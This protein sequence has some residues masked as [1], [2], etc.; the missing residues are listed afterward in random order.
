[1]KKPRTGLEKAGNVLEELGVHGKKNGSAKKPPPEN[2]LAKNLR[3]VTNRDYAEEVRQAQLNLFREI[4]PL[5]G[6]REAGDIAVWQVALCLILCGL[7]YDETSDR[8]VTRRARLADGSRLSVTFTA[9][10]YRD[11]RDANGELLI[12]PA[13][14]KV[15]TTPIPL[16]FGADRGPLHF[17]INK[18]VLQAKE[19]ERQGLETT[20]AR[21]VHWETAA[22]FLTEMRMARGGKNRR[23]L[24][25]RIERIKYC[26]ITV[27]RTKQGVDQTLLAPVFSRTRLPRSL[28]ASMPE[29]VE[30]TVSQ[31]A[32]IMGV[33]FSQDFFDEFLRNHMPVPVELLRATMGRSQIQDYVLWL[34]W[35]A[36]AA[37]QDTLIPWRSVREQLW[38]NDS[39]E[40]RLYATM[41]RAIATL[42]AVWPEFRGEVNPK[43]FGPDEKKAVGLLVGPP[44]NGVYMFN[45]ESARKQIAVIAKPTKKR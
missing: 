23:D 5:I 26:A 18:A 45:S 11:E 39:T 1:M 20:S 19:L 31:P 10:G 8:S 15:K 17:L 41:R 30:I 29:Q 3:L 24:R 6:Q 13:T 16:P 7:P 44:R 14:G 9:M 34:Y 36:F 42:R 4:E 22:Q 2:G 28:D 25:A 33:E 12:D 43:E 32:P 21:F 38:Q 37:K 27:V 40:Q 35:R